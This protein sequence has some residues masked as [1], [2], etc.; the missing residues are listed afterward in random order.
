MS[1]HTDNGMFTLGQIGWVLLAGMLLEQGRLTP[2]GLQ[3]LVAHYCA[4]CLLLWS[5]LY[6]ISSVHERVIRVPHDD[7][8]TSTPAASGGDERGSGELEQGRPSSSPR[9]RPRG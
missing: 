5:A 7:E 1:D 3:Q 9:I 8:L 6:V 4:A 2:R